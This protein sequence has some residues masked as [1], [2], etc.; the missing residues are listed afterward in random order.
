[1][2]SNKA[3]STLF[4]TKWIECKLSSGLYPQIVDNLWI[5][6]G[7]LCG[8]VRKPTVY[9][10]LKAVDKVDNLYTGNTLFTSP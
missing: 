6:C 10:A 3:Q 7:L 8:I 4:S 1:M 5:S 2:V 9:K